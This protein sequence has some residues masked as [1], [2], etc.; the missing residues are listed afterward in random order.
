MSTATKTA[1]PAS[2][3]FR[4]SDHCHGWNVADVTPQELLPADDMFVIVA[5][6][7]GARTFGRFTGRTRQV[8]GRPFPTIERF[9]V[10]TVVI[11]GAIWGTPGARVAGTLAIH[12]DN[13]TA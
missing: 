9:E 4:P 5:R 8:S 12:P 6:N 13:V 2:T 3:L 7:T 10:D 1:R 11:D